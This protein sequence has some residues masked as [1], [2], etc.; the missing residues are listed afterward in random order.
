MNTGSIMSND[1]LV[2]IAVAYT[3]AINTASAKL[4]VSIDTAK[5]SGKTDAEIQALI[6]TAY[7]V[8]KSDIKAAKKVATIGK[9][10][11]RRE[12]VKM[13]NECKKEKKKDLKEHNNDDK[14]E[15]KNNNSSNG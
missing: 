11:S 3:S 10:N 1:Q 5:A 14:D 9:E 8:W 6:K 13:R 4:K 7:N 12:R 2:A 15:H